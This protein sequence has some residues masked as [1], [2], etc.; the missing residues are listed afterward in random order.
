MLGDG[1]EVVSEIN[2]VL[3][4]W[5][6]IAPEQ[7]RDRSTLLRA[8]ASLDGVYV[9]TLYTPIYEDGRLVSTLPVEAGVPE[10]VAKRTISDLAEWPYPA[11][12]LVPLTEVVHDRLNVEV[13]HGCRAA[14]VS[15]RRG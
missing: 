5:L 14:V 10:A 9:P 1:E 4:D 12:P 15:V 3:R 11:R 6:R 7:V 2:V 13:F 8:L